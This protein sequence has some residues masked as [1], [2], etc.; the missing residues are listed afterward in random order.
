LKF[1]YTDEYIDGQ[2]NTLWMH[3]HAGFSRDSG[4]RR[5]PH[6]HTKL[7]SDTLLRCTM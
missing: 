1:K 6:V 4:V 2:V 3:G 7:S 5:I